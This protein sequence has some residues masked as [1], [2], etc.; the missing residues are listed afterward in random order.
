MN[1]HL[2]FLDLLT[3]FQVKKLAKKICHSSNLTEDLI[4]CC[5]DV[6][7]AEKKMVRA[8]PTR[9]NSMTCAI[10]MA[11][12]LKLALNKLVELPEYNTKNTRLRNLKISQDEWGL[13]AQLC[14]ILLVPQD[15]FLLCKEDPKYSV[16]FP[17]GYGAH[18]SLLHPTPSRGHPADG[19]ANEDARQQDHGYKVSHQCPCR[20]RSRTSST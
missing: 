15:L 14:E 7:I 16:A 4:S 3:P 1:S 12:Y 13:L 8:V 18:I 5:E 2:G 10:K 6:N 20:R 11:L 19:H 17:Q 9:W